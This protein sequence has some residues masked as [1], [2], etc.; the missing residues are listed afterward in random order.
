MATSETRVGILGCGAAA[1]RHHL[2]ALVR[3]RNVRVTALCDPS[4]GQRR[5]LEQRF[6]FRAAGFEDPAEL[7]G[8]PNVDVVHVCSPGYLH[9]EQTLLAIQRGKHV[10]VEKPPAHSA[11]EGRALAEAAE[12]AGVKVGCVFNTRYKPL[13]REL[14]RLLD[15]GV[16]GEIVKVHAVHHGGLVF[17]DA[18]W[19]WDERRSKYLL[20]ENGI[21]LLD[22][23][24]HLLGP[25]ERIIHV[26]P[27][28][29][30][31]INSTTE[32]QALIRF[33]GG[34]TAFVDVT[35]DTTRHST[36]LSE[37]R[38]FGTAQDVT[39][40]HFP[41]LLTLSA[42]LVGPHDALRA[43]LRSFGHFLW[44][45]LSGRMAAYR[46]ASHA[47]LIRR[48]YAW[49]TAGEPFRETIS[50]AIPTLRMLEDLEQYLPTYP[51]G[52]RIGNHASP[53]A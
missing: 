45:L 36:C 33:R 28:V 7:V 3:L 49:I 21:H 52:A 18:D 13:L 48:F 20:Y 31:A 40:R 39:V 38:V 30:Q 35:Q 43:E 10:L 25:H 5:L 26:E 44:L 6:G 37:I 32:V 41:P 19:L 16:V 12:R 27:F 53:L 17:A 24:V 4:E 34:V 50:E 22:F 15:A 14:K 11:A 9:Y 29:Q 1:R 51:R 42:G 47:A 46:N 23:L 2:P 8:S